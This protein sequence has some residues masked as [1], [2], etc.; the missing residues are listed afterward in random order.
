MHR[1]LALVLLLASMTLLARNKHDGV[2]TP[3]TVGD[4]FWVGPAIS[5]TWYDP[6][7]SGEGVVLQM[8]PNGAVVAVWFTYPAHGEP[9]DQ[10]WLL[11]L[12]SFADGNRLV[13][14]SVVQPIGARFGADFDPDDVIRLPWGRFEFEFDDCQHLRLRYEGPA[15]YG[16]GERRLQRFTELDEVQCSGARDLLPNGARAASGMRGKSGTWYVPERAGEGWLVE[17]FPDG[18]SGVYW[19]TFDEAGRQRWIAG[20][21][22]R[23]GDR[24]SIDAPFFTRGARFG[25]AFRPADVQIETFGSIAV[26]FGHCR[27]MQLDYHGLRPELGAARR[28]AVR[29]SGVAGAPCLDALPAPSGGLRWTQ[30]GTLP[31]GGTSEFAAVSLGDHIY[32]LG[33]FSMPRAFRRYSPAT[34]QWTSLPDLPEGRH[35]LAAFAFD[36]GVYAVGGYRT[37]TTLP[38]VGMYRFDLDANR[39]AAIPEAPGGTASNTALLFGRAFVGSEEGSLQEFEPVSRRTRRL[40]A[41]EA[42]VLRDHSQLVAFMDEI[43][44]LGGRLPETGLPPGHSS[45]SL[46]VQVDET[47]SA[48]AR[49]ARGRPGQVPAAGRSMPSARLPVRRAGTDSR[50]PASPVSELAPGPQASMPEQVAQH[51]PRRSSATQESKY[52]FGFRYSRGLRGLSVATRSGPHAEAVLDAADGV[53]EAIRRRAP[54]TPQFR[55]ALQHATEDQAAGRARLLG[56]HA[57][58]PRQPVLG[59]R[60]VPIMSHGCT[61]IAAPRSLRGLEERRTTPARRDSSAC[62]RMRCEPICTPCRPSWSMQ[63]SSS[64]MASAA[65]AAAPCR[66]RHSGA[67][68]AAGPAMWSLSAWCSS[69][70]WC[71]LAQ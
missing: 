56:R 54:G 31:D 2:S 70:A 60:A 61:R 38:E 15:A 28:D 1:F 57:H 32:A 6:Q 35:H 44:M 23:D 50:C 29:L 19:F 25:S 10:A 5:G 43:W 34:R 67:D 30:I 45:A 7:R 51:D 16:S 66:C 65:T 47:Y 52:S 41:S 4:G 24:L 39:W 21:G 58:Q 3:S 55:Q 46:A 49:C 33:G 18:R 17:E 13:M 59:H 37:E 68:S 40:P 42:P 14:D 71:G 26:Q 12:S 36:Q 20:V 27:A 53:R 64:C 11:G 63:R 8:L 62:R 22:R 69:S 9:G 48:G